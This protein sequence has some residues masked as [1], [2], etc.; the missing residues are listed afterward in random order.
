MKYEK[1]WEFINNEDVSKLT[2]EKIEE[3]L[4]FKIDHSFL[5]EKK[6][7]KKYGYEI[8]KIS[9]KEKG[10]YIR[11]I[12]NEKSNWGKKFNKRI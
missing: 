9:L 2:F 6:N 10:V 3:I 12:D 1:L 4:G 5:N 11:R 8:S 7:L